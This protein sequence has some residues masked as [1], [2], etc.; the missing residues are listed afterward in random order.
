MRAVLP[1]TLCWTLTVLL[2]SSALISCGDDGPTGPTSDPEACTSFVVP[3]RLGYR[4]D[5]LNHRISIWETEHR[6]DDGSCRANELYGNFV[7][8]DFSTGETAE[9]AAFIKYSGQPVDAADSTSF[10]AARVTVGATIGPDGEVQMTE[11]LSREELNLRN[12]PHF[13]TIIEGFAFDTS[14]EQSDDYPDNYDPA[15]GYTTRGFGASARIASR[16]KDS[17][18]LAWGLRFEIGASPDRERHN[19]AIEH[20]QV[21]GELDVLIVGVA[22]DELVHTGSKSYTLEYPEPMPLEEQM[23]DPASADQQRMEMSGKSGAGAGFHGFTA[24]DFKLSPPND[25]TCSTRRDCAGGDLCTDGQCEGKYGPQGYYI[26][27]MTVDMTRESYDDSSGDAVFMVNGF[28]SNS[29]EFI[30]FNALHST[31]EADVAWVQ[32]VPAQP[33]V[34]VDEEFETGETTYDLP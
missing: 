2:L 34:I 15:H 20:A 11:T 24:F 30:A 29:T 14:I 21:A 27:E 13:V 23:H 17:L 31:F 28:A 6:P 26:R 16:S 1:R 9:D 3:N 4:W 32:G 22:S 19:G 25:G 7:G 12:Y 8:G 5:R 18:E 33:P 10:G